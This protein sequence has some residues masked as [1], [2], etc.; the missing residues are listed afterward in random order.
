MA[1]EYFGV[2]LFADST[3]IYDCV[4]IC[5]LLAVSLAVKK[6]LQCVARTTQSLA[7]QNTA[8]QLVLHPVAFSDRE[9]AEACG[10]SI[11]FM[12]SAEPVI[13]NLVQRL[14]YAATPRPRSLLSPVGH[15]ARCCGAWLLCLT[16][17]DLCWLCDRLGRHSRWEKIP[18]VESSFRTLSLPKIGF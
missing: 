8:I 10:G 17:E 1:V 3:V 11:D 9:P 14:P 13:P 7:T 16:P 15:G 18:R 12:L 4:W 2:S 5:I 6:S